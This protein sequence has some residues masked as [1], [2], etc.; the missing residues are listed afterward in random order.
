MLD[1]NRVY[2]S[3][4]TVVEIRRSS[5]LCVCQPVSVTFL[6]HLFPS[7]CRP[8]V[9]PLDRTHKIALGSFCSCNDDFDPLLEVGRGLRVHTQVRVVHRSRGDW[10]V[11]VVASLAARDGGRGL[12]VDR[13]AV[14]AR[15]GIA[16]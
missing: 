7:H 15:I 16:N 3:M 13:A 8:R 4:H 11:I 14:L 6:S 5:S 12:V 9:I 2:F 10:L 1:D